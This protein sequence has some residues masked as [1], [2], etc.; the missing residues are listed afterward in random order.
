MK[1]SLTHLPQKKQDELKAVVE[2]IR[3]LIDAELVILFGSYAAA[4]GS[5][6]KVSART[7]IFTN[8]GAT[9]TS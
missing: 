5:R 4:T 2:I 1:K 6:I 9:M 8:T 7:A 3:E